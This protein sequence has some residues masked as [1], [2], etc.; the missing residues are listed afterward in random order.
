LLYRNFLIWYNPSCQFLLFFSWAIRILFRK[1][2][3]YACIVKWF[4]CCCF[5]VSGLLWSI[6]N[7]FLYRVRNRNLMPASMRGCPVFP[8]PFVEKGAFSLTRFWH[9]CQESGGSSYMDLFLG[10]LFY[11]V[12]LCV[13][14]CAS[15][16]WSLLLWLCSITW[17]QVL[18]YLQ[19]CSLCSGRLFEVIC[20]DVRI[21][22]FFYFSEEIDFDGDWWDF[23]GYSIE[24]VNCFWWYSHFCILILIPE[25]GSYFHLLMSSSVHFIRVL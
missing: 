13:C 8:A 5:K 7:W 6:L 14:F 2:V 25:H 1:T 24:S 20:A 18:W 12:G 21:F 9:L 23:D 17:S 10:L 11:F 19:H 15:T 22:G 3:T 16:M 4:L